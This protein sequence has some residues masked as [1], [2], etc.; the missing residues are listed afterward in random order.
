MDNDT[1]RITIEFL[2]QW[3]QPVP[4]K[5]VIVGMP[6][7]RGQVV[8]LGDVVQVPVGAIFVRV[9]ETEKCP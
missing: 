4:V 1:K 7:V 3:H 6:M 2:N 8:G 9:V 5:P